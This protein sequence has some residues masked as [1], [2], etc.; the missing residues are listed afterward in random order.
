[1]RLPQLAWLS[2]VRAAREGVRPT[3][4][5]GAHKRARVDARSFPL[6]SLEEGAM[7]LECGFVCA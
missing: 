7:M 3:E 1:M 4:H 2:S 5:A 6:H